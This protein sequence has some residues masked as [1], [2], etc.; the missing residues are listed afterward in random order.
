MREGNNFALRFSHT[1]K[2]KVYNDSSPVSVSICLNETNYYKNEFSPMTIHE[3]DAKFIATVDDGVKNLLTIDFNG[4]AESPNRYLQVKEVSVHQRKLNRY[5]YFYDPIID[6][7]WW[8]ALSG[9]EKDH[10][11]DVIHINNGGQFGW[12]GR[13]SYEYY[14]G[15][16]KTSGYLNDAS[17]E[18]KLTN[19]LAQWVFDD[20]SGAMYPWQEAKE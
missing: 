17:A 16:D 10:Y 11:L 12:Y 9:K 14:S 3:V 19:S 6:P 15:T 7:T 1:V 20:G 8:N 4:E 18:D 2:F 5:K 13:V